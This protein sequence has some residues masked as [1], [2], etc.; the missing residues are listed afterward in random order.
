MTVSQQI[1]PAADK[2]E[3]GVCPDCGEDIPRTAVYGDECSNCGHSFLWGDD[4]DKL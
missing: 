1:E 3:G 4:D 2:Y